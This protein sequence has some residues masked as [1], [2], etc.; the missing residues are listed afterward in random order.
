MLLPSRLEYLTWQLQCLFKEHVHWHCYAIVN[1]LYRVARLVYKL[2]TYTKYCVKYY[3]KRIVSLIFPYHW[4]YRNEN[5]HDLIIY[6]VVL[7]RNIDD[8][9][10]LL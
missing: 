5:V 6:T 3:R 1:S 8:A 10:Y 7:D 9:F 4:V 2:K